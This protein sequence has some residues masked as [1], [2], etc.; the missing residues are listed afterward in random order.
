MSGKRV[1]AL[2]V[3]LVVCLAGPAVRG[4]VLW[5]YYP[6]EENDLKDHSGNNHNGTAVDGAVTVKDPV[7]GWVAAFNV[8]P[9]KPSRIN[10][11]IDDPSAGGQLTLAAWLL[12]NGANGN[13]QGIAG[14]SFSYDDRRWI[15]NS[16]IPMA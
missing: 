6:I 16:A 12:W 7:R 2:C 1:A 4:Q 3:L 15:S 5:G 9:A 13:W 8:E 14:K 10:L 11:G